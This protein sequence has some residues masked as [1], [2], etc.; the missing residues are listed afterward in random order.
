MNSCGVMTSLVGL[1]FYFECFF[2]CFRSSG[3]KDLLGKSGL[4]RFLGL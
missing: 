3:D 2:I 4:G 1:N